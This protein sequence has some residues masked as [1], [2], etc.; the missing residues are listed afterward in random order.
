[1][2]RSGVTVTLTGLGA[3]GVAL[4][5]MALAAEHFGDML[6]WFICIVL[7]I[8]CIGVT[9]TAKLNAIFGEK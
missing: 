3:L 4:F 8:G 2:S 1:M 9:L 5:G 7:G 6:L